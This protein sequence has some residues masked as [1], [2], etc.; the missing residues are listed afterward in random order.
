MGAA[1]VPVPLNVMVCTP[2]PSLPSTSQVPVTGPLAVGVN[3]TVS[4]MDVAGAIVSGGEVPAS[5]VKGFVNALNPLVVGGVDEV[6]VKG[7]P[8]W[9]PSW[10]LMVADV[11]TAT[12]PKLRAAGMVVI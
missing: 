7:R 6:M 5:W 9:S 4:W 2:S 12:F 3:F 8:P 11:P 10:K 1:P